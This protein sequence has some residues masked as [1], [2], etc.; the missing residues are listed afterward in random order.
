MDVAKQMMVY[1]GDQDKEKGSWSIH[2]VPTRCKWVIGDVYIDP[3]VKFTS[4][5]LD[6]FYFFLIAHSQ[7]EKN[8]QEWTPST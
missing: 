5:L 8:E 1:S 6:R 2:H 7:T 3:Q 4:C